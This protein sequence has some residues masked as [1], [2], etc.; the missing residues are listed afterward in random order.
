MIAGAGLMTCLFISYGYIPTW[1]L[2]N[3]PAFHLPFLDLRTILGA[4]ESYA[5]G[6]NPA[7]DNPFDPLDRK[8]NYPR[9]WYLILAIGIN[10]SWAIP[11]GIAIIVLFLIS[12][13]L[14]AGKLNKLS[15]FFIVLALFSP[16][17]LFSMERGNVDLIFFSMLALGLILMNISQ[18]ASLLVWVTGI[19]FKIYPIF[20]AGYFLDQEKRSSLKYIGIGAGITVLYFAL[21]YHDMLT[22]LRNTVKGQDISYG[23]A[24]LPTYFKWIVKEKIGKVDQP[25]FYQAAVFLNNIYSSFP[26]LPYLAAALI[27][28]VLTCL[29]IL[30]K[31]QLSFSNLRNLRAFWLGAGIYIGTF[32][33]GNNWDYRLIFLLFTLPQLAEW[34]RQES[35]SIRAAAGTT[36]VA[37]FLSLWYFVLKAIVANFSSLAADIH[38]VVDEIIN[39]ILFGGL[40][41]LYAASVPKWIF[42]DVRSAAANILS[43]I[44]PHPAV[45]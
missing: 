7:Q 21:T 1:N 30:R 6:Y 5:A 38:P 4:A 8:F 3:I 43:G 14:F 45:K 13:L 10:Q 19:L 15:I 23:V 36:T 31:K 40:I 33:L 34:I 9:I 11:L 39:W 32:L 25:S 16:A 42:S 44:K 17:V 20:G 22:V 29:G 12:V 35:G 41:Y 18:P 2:W 26:L 27:I 28:L 37:L 24:V